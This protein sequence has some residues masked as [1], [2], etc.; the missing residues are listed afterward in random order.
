M[1][2]GAGTLITGGTDRAT[3][4]AG[5]A[6]TATFVTG[7][8]GTGGAAARGAT[9]EI[10][11]A[12]PLGTGTAAN[13][14][15]VALTTLEGESTVGATTFAEEELDFFFLVFLSLVFLE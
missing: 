12:T 14:T 10:T 15:L 2:V 13:E 1:D 5:I 3:L 7:S 9:T 11:G 6:C 8:I 4:A